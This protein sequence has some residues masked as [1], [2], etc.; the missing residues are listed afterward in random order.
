LSRRPV[1]IVDDDPDIVGVARR[2][3]ERAGFLVESTTDPRSAL[4]IAQRCQPCLVLVDLMM[5]YI[6]GEELVRDLRA[7]LDP[8]PR[9]AL[10]SAAYVR[11]EVA[12]RLDAD[13]SLE[14]PFE[15]D[16][17]RDLVIGL[18]SEH[19]DRRSSLLPPKPRV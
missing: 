14:K 6:D 2:T 17:L 5:P 19:R 15:L 11:A 8:P 1:L 18:A 7:H 10:V 4:E 12:K 16:D 9:I 13:G 3:L